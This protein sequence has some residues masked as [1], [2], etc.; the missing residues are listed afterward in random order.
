MDNFM[1][2]KLMKTKDDEEKEKMKEKS[3]LE[4][5]GVEVLNLNE[6]TSA[7]LEMVN[8]EEV[9]KEGYTARKNN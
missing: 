1:F 3:T 7:S 8:T 5:L 2:Q 6:K 9:D 4:D